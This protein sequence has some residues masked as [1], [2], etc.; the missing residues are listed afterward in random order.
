MVLG[1]VKENGMLGKNYPKV[2]TFRG[3]VEKQGSRSRALTIG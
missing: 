3:T 1:R 2:Q